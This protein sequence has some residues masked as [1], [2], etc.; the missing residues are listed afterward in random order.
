MNFPKSGCQA[1]NSAFNS[2][3]KRSVQLSSELKQ[4]YS[5]FT[6][7]LGICRENFASSWYRK[8]GGDLHGMRNVQKSWDLCKTCSR[9]AAYV[10][11]GG[12]E[13]CSSHVLH[14]KNKSIL[15]HILNENGD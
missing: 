4:I 8:L 2:V 15:P 10:S 14:D 9:R 7:A 11:D 12:I 6:T 5:S 3:A 1:A 13:L